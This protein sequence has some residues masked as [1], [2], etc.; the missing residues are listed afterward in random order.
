MFGASKY[1]ILYVP[2]RFSQSVIETSLKHWHQQ[3]KYC[4]EPLYKGH[5]RQSDIYIYILYI[6][7]LNFIPVTNLMH[8]F[9][10]SYNATVLYMF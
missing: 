5:Q 9:L 4:S 1:I 2:K 8:K 10:Y 6:D 7:I 3:Y